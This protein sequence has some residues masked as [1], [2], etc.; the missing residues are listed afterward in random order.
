MAAWAA[1]VAA[2]VIVLGWAARVALGAHWPSDVVLTSL[3]CLAWVWAARRVIL[4]AS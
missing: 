1:G 2:T 4:P 3:V